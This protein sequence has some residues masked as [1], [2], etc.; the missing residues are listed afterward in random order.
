MAGDWNTGLSKLDK[1]GGLPWKETNNR[2]ALVNLM[3]ELN[4]FIQFIRALELIHTN[5]KVCDSNQELIFSLYQNNS[6]MM[7]SK[8]KLAHQ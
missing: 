6:S 3:R 8:Q 7:Q 2:N 4:L 1:S 5:R